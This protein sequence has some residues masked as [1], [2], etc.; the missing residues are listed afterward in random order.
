[1]LVVCPASWLLWT[2]PPL[3]AMEAW[4]GVLVAG[5]LL[6][7]VVWLGRRGVAVAVVATL[8][9]VA[10]GQQLPWTAR[11]LGL[12]ALLVGMLPPWRWRQP[13]WQP[14]RTDVDVIL[15]VVMECSQRQWG[16][17]LVLLA[18]PAEIPSTLPGVQLQ[19]RLSAELLL[20]LLSPLS[21]LHDGAIVISQGKVLAAGVIVP[22]STQSL[23]LGLGTRH[24][25]ALGVTEQQPDGVAIVVSE[26]TG[27]VALARRGQL[28]ANLT[29]HQ[30]RKHLEPGN[31]HL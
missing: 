15:K 20:S 24:R 13:V 27:Q 1:V 26:E 16:A 10:E 21:P 17:L 18:P 19:A 14:P 6:F 22:I 25:A 28:L 11:G 3:M 12:T 8:A 30:L 9:L 31:N 29:P 5:V 2:R 7:L 23:D 4:D